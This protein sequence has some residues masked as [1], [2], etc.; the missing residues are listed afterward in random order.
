MLPKR[1]PGTHVHGAVVMEN[2][3]LVFN[4]EYLGMM[5]LNACGD[6]VWRLPYQT[7]HS[8]DMDENTGNLWVSGRIYHSEPTPKFPNHTPPFSEPTAIEVS[9]DGDILKEI[10]VIELLQKN[11]LHA[12]LHMK[13]FDNVSSKN[14][15]SKAVATG[16]TLHLND[17]EAFP[18]GLPA[19]RFKPGDLMLSLR[20]IHTVLVFDPRTEEIVY[21]QTGG[22][23][24]QHD[25]DFIDGNTISVF[26]NAVGIGDETLESRVVML[27]GDNDAAEPQIYYKGNDEAPFYTQFMG[28]HQ[29]LSNGNLLLTESM[30]GRAFEIDKHGDI[31]W[32]YVNL[33]DDEGM[34]GL[35]EEAQR[36]PRQYDR[37]FFEDKR[38][39]C[40]DPQKIA[41]ESHRTG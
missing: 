1:Q 4:F 14:E 15:R 38:R 11:D 37:A 34:V 27:S 8:I 26:D 31:V 28:K 40:E 22:F 41:S 30:A 35:I 36:L 12:L 7:H 39:T 25:P 17:V 29:W 21:R 13:V 19:G 16:D 32:Q 9:P 6:V 18:R 20:N 23:V 2:G 33:I 3:D 24:G 10:S 5:R